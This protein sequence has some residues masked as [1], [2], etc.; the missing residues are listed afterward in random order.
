[1]PGAASSTAPNAKPSKA[2]SAIFMRSSCP[3]TA[4]W[5]VTASAVRFNGALKMSGAFGVHL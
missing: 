2:S 1:M 4:L 5:C 3:E